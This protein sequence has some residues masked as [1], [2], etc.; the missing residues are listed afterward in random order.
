M[1]L[2]IKEKG[3]KNYYDE[4]LYLVFNY[5][6]I[7]NNPYKKIKRLTILGYSYFGISTILSILLFILYN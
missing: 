1:K 2:E 7:R 5:K 4:F 6:K 3:S